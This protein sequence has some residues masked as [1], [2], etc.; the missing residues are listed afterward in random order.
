[1]MRYW[2]DI[3]Y[4]YINIYVLFLI[5]KKKSTNNLMDEDNANANNLK[6]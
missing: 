4:L 2:F 3:I 5:C 1:M 6:K